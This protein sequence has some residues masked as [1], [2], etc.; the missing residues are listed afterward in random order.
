MDNVKSILRAC[1]AVFLEDAFA[2]TK[3][4]S[5][6]VEI[7][8]TLLYFLVLLGRVQILTVE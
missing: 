7:L 1:T 4:S 2:K 6:H 3:F 8:H 5:N